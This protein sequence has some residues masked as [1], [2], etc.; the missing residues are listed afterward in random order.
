M[1]LAWSK[2]PYTTSPSLL[3]PYPKPHTIFF[4]RRQKLR[5]GVDMTYLKNVV[6]GGLISGELPAKS[7]LVPVLEKLLQFSPDEHARVKKKA[8]EQPTSFWSLP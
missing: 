4:C 5:E 1:L 2:A 7:S 6:L 3:Y 8:L